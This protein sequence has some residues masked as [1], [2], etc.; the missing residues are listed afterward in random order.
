MPALGGNKYMPRKMI[1]KQQL[2]IYQT[3]N[4]AIELREDRDNET[5]WASQK[6]MA[7][8]FGVDVRT[9]SE[10]ILNIFKTKELGKKA[11]IRKF[12]IVQKEGNRDV[13]RNIDHYNLDMIISV[14]YRINS[15][16][17]TKFRQWATKTLRSYITEGYVINPQRIGKNYDKFLAAVEHVQKLLPKDTTIEAGDILELIKTFASTW[18]S[19]ESYD[20]D[21][22]PQKG[23][24]KK[25]VKIQSEDLYCAIATFKDT[26]IQQKQATTLFAKERASHS[27][28]GIL[29]NVMQ[30]AFDKEMYPS[31]ESKAAHLLYFFIKDHPFTDGNKR[32]GAF[33]FVWFLQRSGIKFKNKITPEALTT[34]TLLVAQ[35]HP[36]DKERMIGL[37]LLLLNGK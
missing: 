18:F 12:R 19:L 5:I 31:I 17:A 9:I 11:T 36:R 10:H 24:T 7:D 21:A 1:K 15:K 14:G 26:L 6:Q 23:V 22:L 2:A 4:G 30:K 34:I 16:T 20:E 3:K 13:S 27:V 29:G 8:V 35:S 37:V 25:T 33:A 28:E 32:T